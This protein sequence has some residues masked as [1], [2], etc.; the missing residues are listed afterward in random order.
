MQQKRSAATTRD[1]PRILAI[2]SDEPRFAIGMPDAL[3]E[4]TGPLAEGDGPGEWLFEGGDGKAWLKEELRGATQRDSELEAACPCI[5]TL[6]LDTSPKLVDVREVSAGEVEG[7]R[8]AA[9]DS[10]STV[11]AVEVVLVAGGPGAGE[12]SPP[13]VQESSSGIEGP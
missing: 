9:G 11:I 8:D 13:Y 10:R 1:G 3:V 6:I 12:V 5:P 4:V 2:S 7:P